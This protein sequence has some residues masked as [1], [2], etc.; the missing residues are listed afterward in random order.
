[1]DRLD[2]LLQLAQQFY[3]DALGLACR[4][5]YSGLRFF[6]GHKLR[7]E[8]DPGQVRLALDLITILRP[9]EDLLQEERDLMEKKLDPRAPRRRRRRRPSAPET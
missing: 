7:D 1:M 2:A 6:D 3:P 5:L 9:K 8:F 4:R